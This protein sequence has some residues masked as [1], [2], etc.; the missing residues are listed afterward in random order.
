MSSLIWCDDYSVN[1]RSIDNEHKLLME[2]V[3]ELDSAL[4]TQ[5]HVLLQLVSA[6]L[7]QLSHAIRMHFDSE[8]R[9]LL[10]NNY[11]DSVNHQKEHNAL[12]MKLDDFIGNFSSE[13][14]VFTEQMSL[15]I[16]DWFVRHIILHDR[17]FGNFFR[18]K[19]LATPYGMN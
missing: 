3:K 17:K 12:L 18:D 14:L 8:E 7:K 10:L 9:F 16:K 19:E 1:I 6:A 13:Q 5:G 2:M 4:E 11:P 15:Y